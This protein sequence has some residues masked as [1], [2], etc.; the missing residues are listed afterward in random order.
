MRSLKLTIVLFLTLCASADAWYTPTLQTLVDWHARL[1]P[2][3]VEGS[4][5]DLAA[6]LA[7][8]EFSERDKARVIF[9]WMTERI[10]FNADAH[11]TGTPGELRPENVLGHR[12]ATA[13]G[14]AHLY[15]ALARKAGLEVV[16]VY[17][18]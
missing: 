13:F 11:F 8:P 2:R 6:Y 10:R 1:A 15:E 16:T 14:Y 12:E 5:D 3:E 7:K 4:L 17:G 18:Y 9:R